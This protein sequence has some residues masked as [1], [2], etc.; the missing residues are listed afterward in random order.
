MGAEIGWRAK[1]RSTCTI[2]L[3][4]TLS[5][6]ITTQYRGDKL[7]NIILYRSNKKK[8]VFVSQGVRTSILLQLGSTKWKEASIVCAFHATLWCGSTVKLLLIVRR[9]CN[10]HVKLHQPQTAELGRGNA[11]LFVDFR[12]PFVDSPSRVRQGWGRPHILLLAEDTFH[13]MPLSLV[14]TGMPLSSASRRPVPNA[15]ADRIMRG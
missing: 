10:R 7:F 1:Q 4:C 11:C 15:V 2:L 12:N 14:Q 6:G 8:R 5:T 13:G 9:A 3:I